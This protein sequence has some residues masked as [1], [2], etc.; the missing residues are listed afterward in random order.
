MFVVFMEELFALK[1]IAFVHGGSKKLDHRT[2]WFKEGPI[3]HT[4]V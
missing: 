2:L 3:F 1:Y 4:A